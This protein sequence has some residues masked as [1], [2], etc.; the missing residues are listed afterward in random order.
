MGTLAAFFISPNRK[1]REMGKRSGGDQVDM[2][3]DD[4]ACEYSRGTGLVLLGC[5]QQGTG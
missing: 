2:E 4:N 3:L 5:R 1:Q